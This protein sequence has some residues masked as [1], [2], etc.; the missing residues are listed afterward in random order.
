[1]RHALPEVAIVGLDDEPALHVE[2]L[3]RDGWFT[4]RELT[5]EDRRRGAMYRDERL[6]S[7]FQEGFAGSLADY[8][9]ELRV[10]VRLAPVSDGEVPRV[11]QLTQRTNQFNL[12]TRRWQASDLRDRLDDADGQVLAVSARDRFGENG[13][14]GAVF[15]SR[16][17]DGLRLDNFVLSC[18]VFSR[19]IEQACLAAVLRH[20]RNTGAAW[21]EGGY[22]PT[23]KNGI[24]ARLYPQHG[25]AE[26]R[27]DNDV[28]WF[29]HD[30]ADTL[31]VP[32]HV[33]LTDGL[34]EAGQ[35]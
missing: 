18:R 22:R 2:K 25:F 7:T 34:N 11:A 35:L 8:L 20:A 5:D 14:V 28:T 12:T 3:L 24:V 29:R 15:L 21:V 31:T 9:R 6:R 23:P 30:L 26:H 27:V 16:V 4:V 17:G 19:G 32:D 1:V 33:S 10:Q 13:L